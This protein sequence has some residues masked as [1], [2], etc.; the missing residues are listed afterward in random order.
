MCADAPSGRAS[1]LHGI[2]QVGTLPHRNPDTVLGQILYVCDLSWPSGNLHFGIW[3]LRFGLAKLRPMPPQP[4]ASRS[5]LRIG[6]GDEAPVRRRMVHPVQMHQFVDQNVIAHRCRHQH[7][8]PVQAD[9]TVTPAGTPPRSLI[10]H[11]DACHG[12][13]VLRCQFEQSCGQIAACL[14]SQQPLAFE[15]PKFA[16]GT[17]SLSDDP[18]DV[19]LNERLGLA[20]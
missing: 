13:P 10:A 9:M 6:I 3:D 17:C 20:A 5:V 7:Q 12:E 4:V 18:V 11:A 2:A 14:L 8:S 15:G 1:M 19:P 16:L